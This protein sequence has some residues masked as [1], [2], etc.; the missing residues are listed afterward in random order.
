[1]KVLDEQ[2]SIAERATARRHTAGKEYSNDSVWLFDSVRGRGAFTEEEMALPAPEREGRALAR[3]LA[4]VP[5]GH[6]PGDLL[7]GDVGLH[8]LSSDERQE[9]EQEA[10]ARKAAPAET[11]PRSAAAEMARRFRCEAGYTPAHTCIDQERVLRDGLSGILTQVNVTLEATSDGAERSLYRGMRA[12]LEG[13]IAFAHRYCDLL[14]QEAKAV[15]DPAERGRLLE[16]AHICRHVPDHPPRTF[17]EAVQALCLLR[18]VTGLSEYSSASLSLGRLDQLLLPFYRRE[19]TSNRERERLGVILVDFWLKLNRFGDAAIAVNLGGQG[20]EGQDQ[21]NELTE[22]M[23]EVS[24]ALPLPAPLLAF[25]VHQKTTDEQLTSVLVP[26]LLTR[27]QP[28]FYGEEACREAL[29]RR[30]VTE[31]EAIDFA[32]NS[33]M[34]L[35]VPGA[36]FADMWAAKVPALLAL[37]LA[38][39]AGEP[40][41]GGE[42]PLQLRTT[43]RVEFPDL[44]SI[45]AQWRDYQS[46]LIAFCMAEH[47]QSVAQRAVE[48]PNP[49]L[50]ALLDGC[51]QR[52]RNHCEGGVRYYTAT[53]DGFGLVNIADA[54][55]AIERLVFRE[56]RYALAELVAAAKRNYEGDDDAILHHAILECPAYGYGDRSADAIAARVASAYAELVSAHSSSTC[57]YLPAFHTLNAH[58][59]VGAAYGASLDGRRRGE[60]LAK[61]IGPA[62]RRG[63]IELTALMQ[64]ASDIDQAAL[65]GGQAL[66]ISVDPRELNTQP[67]RQSFRDAL[68]VYFARGGLE[69]QVNGVSA[70]TLR[71][72]MAKPEDYQ[73]LQV[74]IAGFSMRFVNLSRDVQEEMVQ[75]FAD[76][77]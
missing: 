30:G 62:R 4:T 61:N 73:D 39:N 24:T 42:P 77:L 11:G 74:R 51:I 17:H 21:F 40:F 56:Q 34:G 7:V 68:S 70:D 53:F 25:R 9:L 50:S 65:S 27:G 76:G 5:I 54:L 3:L 23:V 67:G 32:V 66:D 69:V 60:P 43:P 15:A 45:F 44:E 64:A 1:M 13:T 57:L 49:F 37:E 19:C 72:A 52:G 20:A 75:R 16:L 31:T 28:T 55:V 47:R 12:A 14:V 8:F 38:V 71:A 2:V 48:K 18:V 29:R 35:V 59:P 26:E 63:R 41:Q 33:C 36:E 22:L 6:V 46:E 58:I 10:A